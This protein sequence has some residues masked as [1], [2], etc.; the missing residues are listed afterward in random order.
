VSGGS[1]EVRKRSLSS[2]TDRKH[3]TP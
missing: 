1:Q 2:A 3:W